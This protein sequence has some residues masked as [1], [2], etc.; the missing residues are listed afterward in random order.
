MQ[1]DPVPL[2]GTTTPVNNAAIAKTL[3]VYHFI[4]LLVANDEPVSVAD[5]WFA[6]VTLR[7]VLETPW[8]QMRA[9]E[10]LEA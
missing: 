3:N 10:P 9:D 8:V 1:D 6:L 5:E 7:I 4:A 2:R